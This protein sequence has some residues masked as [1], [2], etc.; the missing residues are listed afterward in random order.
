MQEVCYV[1]SYEYA[2][3]VKKAT[4]VSINVF[5]WIR[6]E[7]G[8]FACDQQFYQLIRALQISIQRGR[9]ACLV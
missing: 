2:V 9:V 3:P 4:A 1:C 5:S 8:Q 7:S 6:T